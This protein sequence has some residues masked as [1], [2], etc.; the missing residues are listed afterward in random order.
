MCIHTEWTHTHTYTHVF[1]VFHSH[2]VVFT[3][4]QGL[5]VTCWTTQKRK[6]DGQEARGQ[7]VAM[8]RA[9]SFMF[10]D[11]FASSRSYSFHLLMNK[12]YILAFNHRYHFRR[13]FAWAS[14]HPG[15]SEHL[16]P[17]PSLENECIHGSFPLLWA[18]ELHFLC[19]FK[20]QI[21]NEAK[22]TIFCYNYSFGGKA[23]LISYP[24]K[25]CGPYAVGKCRVHSHKS[26]NEWIVMTE[27]NKWK[28]T[29]SK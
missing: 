13:P 28:L 6:K 22:C 21:E 2:G 5:P 20:H 11:N 23:L 9:G 10:F 16:F 1:K 18:T 15:S 25:L 8:P 29:S 4:T 17:R 27:R 14:P 19:T 12:N 7:Q 3:H 24:R 26:D